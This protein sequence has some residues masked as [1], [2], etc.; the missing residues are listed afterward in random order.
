MRSLSVQFGLLKVDTHLDLHTLSWSNSHS[1]WSLL[2]G[3]FSLESKLILEIADTSSILLLF[4]GHVVHRHF[5]LER[6]IP[7][8]VR[9]SLVHLAQLGVDATDRLLV[10]CHAAYSLELA[11]I[12]CGGELIGD[13][14]CVVSREVWALFV[15]ILTQSVAKCHRSSFNSVAFA[16]V[17][18]W[19]GRTRLLFTWHL[20]WHRGSAIWG[21]RLL[22]STFNH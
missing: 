16:I 22:L 4:Q 17:L 7:L 21:K 9:L 3:N 13:L 20:F 1:V 14:T 11:W 2:I 12:I 6:F 8:Q 18:L 10:T 15:W 19:T 5:S